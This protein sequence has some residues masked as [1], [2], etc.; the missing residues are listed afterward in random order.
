M[1]IIYIDE[2]ILINLI[3]DYFLC[4]GS[5][6]VCGVKLRRARYL[7]AAVFGAVYCALSVLPDMDF[8][9]LAPIKLASGVLMALIS[10]GGEAKL[11]RCCLVFFAVSAFFGGAV[12]VLGGRSENGLY[13][14]ISPPV[15]V[16]SFGLCYALLS[17]VFRRSAK[18]AA[19]QVLDVKLSLGGKT[20]CLHALFDSG[21]TLSDPLTGDRVLVCSAGS[22][23]AL[24]DGT[25]LRCSPFELAL[26]LP[27][28]FRLIPY[29]SVGTDSGMLAAFRPD[30]LLIGG[31]RC[32]D[33]LAAVSAADIQG[34]GFDSVIGS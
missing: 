15:L 27:G 25:D 23:T 21:S 24:F 26:S 31:K 19:R 33:V 29:R 22:L 34:D 1:D 12:W 9:L 28:F 20:V 10:F 16:L 8:L 14:S 5:A 4:L 30:E 18:T 17:T 3:I 13:I 32:D 11:L 2:L 6:R 7:A